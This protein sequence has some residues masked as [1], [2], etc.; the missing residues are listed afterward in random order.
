MKATL[1][2]GVLGGEKE[3]WEITRDE[4]IWGNYI[5]SGMNTE[6]ALK[7]QVK[8]WQKRY[9]SFSDSEKAPL[10]PD[11]GIVAGL[12]RAKEHLDKANA[13]RDA[14]AKALSENK[15][16][17][18]EVL[19]DY[20]DLA[21]EKG[22][23]AKFQ[24]AAKTPQPDGGKGYGVVK[25]GLPEGTVIKVRIPNSAPSGGSIEGYL[26][27]NGKILIDGD[28]YSPNDIAYW[29]MPDHPNK[30]KLRK[31]PSDDVL[32][33]FKKNAGSQE[34]IDAIYDVLWK[35]DRKAPYNG[36]ADNPRYNNIPQH[37]RLMVRNLEGEGLVLP[38]KGRIEEYL[39]NHT[40]KNYHEFRFNTGSYLHLTSEPRQLSPNER[41][42]IEEW[43]RA[44][45]SLGRTA[46]VSLGRG[47]ESS[48]WGYESPEGPE[49]KIGSVK[50]E[51]E[52]P[53]PPVS[54]RRC[55]L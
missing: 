29:G 44:G 37:K 9:D 47:K 17:P 23:S 30:T 1:T 49:K 3:P 26:G 35:V 55:P 54:G 24:L 25:G 16:V 45:G 39:L 42:A 41:M 18:P 27:R 15:P 31:N 19:K 46:L 2:I 36:R 40:L 53:T 12:M 28:W 5:P 11:N 50:K 10:L 4:A 43:E 14:V 33:S 8:L 21:R 34:Q 48:A 38:S 20:P 32:A 52:N 7:A 13:H 51:D 22:G 6:R